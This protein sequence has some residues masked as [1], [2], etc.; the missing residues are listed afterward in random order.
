MSRLGLIVSRAAKACGIVGIA[1]CVS[2]TAAWAAGKRVA[3]VVGNG[4]YQAVPALTNPKN[5]AKAV[6]EALRKVGFEVVTAIDLDRQDF[7]KAVEK[8]IRSLSDAELSLFY[9]SGHGVEVDGENRIIPVDAKL[10]T[11]AALEVETVSLQTIMLHMRNNSRAQLLYLDACR[12]NPFGVKKFVVGGDEV[13]KSIGRGLAREK[14]DIGSLIAYA[15]EPG[16]IAQDGEGD[17]SPFTTAVLRHSFD[18]NKDVQ[19]A[20]LEVT[21]E[22]WEA[23]KQKQRPWSNATL[24]EPIFLNG[25][26]VKA[27]KPAEPPPPEVKKVAAETATAEK[28]A[29]A[30]P[31]PEV[32]KTAPEAVAIEKPT[33]VE[34]PKE[35]AVAVEKTKPAT[36]TAEDVQTPPV[37][38]VEPQK[39]AAAIE[40]PAQ[41]A[42]I[43]AGAQPVFAKADIEALLSSTKIT[44]AETPSSGTVSLNGETLIEG[45]EFDAAALAALKFEPSH[46]ETNSTPTLS[47]EATTPE[48]TVVPV[49]V[50]Q[51]VEINPCDVEAAEPLDLQGTQKGVL[52][53]E[54]NIEKALAAC[55][56]AVKDYPDVARFI[57]QLGRAELA[58]KNTDE[59][60]KLFDKAAE[61]GHIRAHHQMGYMAQRGIG[62]PQSI[63]EANVYYKIGAEKGD[64]Y[65]MMTYGR[66]LVRGRGVKADVKLGISYLNRAVEMGHTYAMN[67]LGYMYLEGGPVKKNP[68][69][70]V[71][72]FEASMS[73][74]D[75][76]GM[77]NMANAYLN[78]LGVD[79]D[80]GTALALYTAASDAGHPYAPTDIGAIYFNGAG[81]K[82]DIGEAIKWYEIG[83]ERGSRQAASNLGWIFS[84]GPKPKRDIVKAVQY[85]ALAAALDVYNQD[86]DIRGQLAKL[87]EKSKSDAVK[88]LIK[89]IGPE[90]L[91]TAENLDETLILL[92]RKAWQMR[93]PRL[94]L[95]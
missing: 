60:N 62:R 33:E 88:E 35:V 22:V 95:F 52:P 51:D 69:R 12:D 63:E 34:N 44:L 4:A 74:N 17:N 87:P 27:E 23:T 78:G 28:P 66:N 67:E 92:S 38:K 82:K 79:K 80:P 37:E 1:L 91:V 72:F 93:N 64:P 56:Q 25:A 41:I 21:R 40:V 32:E 15:T 76:Y 10:A 75:I 6:S 58:A 48:G 13:K 55:R 83:A 59:A 70:A 9:Y 90:N 71:R 47:I 7:D 36:E 26:I 68:K 81:V 46:D 24:V 42:T 45:S 94:D 85:T 3:F 57:F 49:V 16:N 18:A 5:D 43:G 8:F 61:A 89:T 73:R 86:K 39:T 65:A 53:N 50:K 19:T 84:Q 2:N 20:M 54:I 30:P 14:A 77:Q 29:E 31:P 11:E